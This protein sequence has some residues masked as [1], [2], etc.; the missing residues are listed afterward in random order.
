M[1]EEGIVNAFTVIV[2][3]VVRRAKRSK[4]ARQLVRKNR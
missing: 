4:S 2:K 1:A 3:V